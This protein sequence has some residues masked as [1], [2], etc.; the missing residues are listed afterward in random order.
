MRLD[1]HS[2]FFERVNTRVYVCVCVCASIEKK[3]TKKHRGRKGWSWLGV[4]KQEFLARKS[5]TCAHVSKHHPTCH[6]TSLTPIPVPPLLF[7]LPIPLGFLPLSTT[8]SHLYPLRDADPSSSSFLLYPSLFVLSRFF[9]FFI[10]LLEN[11]HKF[12][13][14][15]LLFPSFLS[16]FFLRFVGFFFFFLLLLS[17]LLLLFSFFFYLPSFVH[18]HRHTRER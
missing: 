15:F 18:T 11:M 2:S 8:S 14:S 7:P 12:S 10:Y 16:F 4:S 13:S 5:T 1:E 3:Q 17:F 6:A 9:F